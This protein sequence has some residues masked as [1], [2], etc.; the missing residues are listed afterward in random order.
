MLN[1]LKELLETVDDN[2]HWDKDHWPKRKL[3]FPED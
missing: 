1:F 3:G 2:V